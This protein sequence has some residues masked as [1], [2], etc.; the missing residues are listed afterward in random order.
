M[1]GTPWQE[2]HDWAEAEKTLTASYLVPV[3]ITVSTQPPTET[4]GPQNERNQPASLGGLSVG[5]FPGDHTVPCVKFLKFEGVSVT[6][7]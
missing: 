6:A 5:H 3:P 7:A 2:H 4:A 1:V